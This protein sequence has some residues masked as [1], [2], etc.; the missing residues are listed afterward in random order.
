MLKVLLLTNNNKTKLSAVLETLTNFGA[1]SLCIAQLPERAAHSHLVPASHSP[2]NKPESDSHPHPPTAKVT[3][4]LFVASH[5]GA[6][7]CLTPHSLWHHWLCLILT[8]LFFFFLFLT[9][10]IL[11]L[12]LWLLL[13][14]Q[15]PPYWC[16]PEICSLFSSHSSDSPP[17]SKCLIP[18]PPAATD[19]CSGCTLY[20]SREHHSHGS[21]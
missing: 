6:L 1:L 3:S 12:H 17:N 2:P 5:L 16:S 18:S 13:L 4:K 8:P 20:H 19:A 9:R 7:P 10:L 14:P 21:H 15:T 11:P